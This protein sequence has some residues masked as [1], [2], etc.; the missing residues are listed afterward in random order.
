[1]FFVFVVVVY[2]F[3]VRFYIFPFLVSL[4]HQNELFF[5]KVPVALQAPM[6]VTAKPL[7]LEQRDYVVQAAPLVFLELWVM[8]GTSAK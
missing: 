1:M 2:V 6:G 5:P 4:N 8:T 7:L 3:A